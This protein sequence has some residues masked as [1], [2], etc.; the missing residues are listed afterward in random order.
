MSQA[1]SL[2]EGLHHSYALWK[3]NV[4]LLSHVIT[5]YY[6]MI[7]IESWGVDINEDNS[8][9]DLYSN[10][11]IHWPHSVSCKKRKECSLIPCVPATTTTKSLQIGFHTCKKNKVFPSQW[12][13]KV[14]CFWLFE[15]W[16]NRKFQHLSSAV[17][18]EKVT[19]DIRDLLI[20]TFKLRWKTLTSSP[21]LTRFRA[22]CANAYFFG[23]M[24]VFF[25]EGVIP[26]FPSPGI[27]TVLYIHTHK[28]IQRD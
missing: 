18:C 2:S 9:H 25:G 16:E 12:Y 6:N 13:V 14:M 22:E 28:H 26:L 1:V 4:W 24:W 15:R 11:L 8:V 17:A 21:L 20:E 5:V 7:L 10:Y 19:D 3:L 23:E 27:P